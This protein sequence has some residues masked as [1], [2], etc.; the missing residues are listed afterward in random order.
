MKNIKYIIYKIKEI[1]IFIIKKDISFINSLGTLNQ[2]IIFYYIIFLFLLLYIYFFIY[3]NY[4]FFLIIWLILL[5]Y[6]SIVDT[7]SYYF[8]NNK[9]LKIFIKDNNNKFN[10]ILK[11]FIFFQKW[12]NPLLLLFLWVDN[13]YFLL[14]RFIIY[15]LK[16]N[17]R[18]SYT[19]SN[20]KKFFFLQYLILNILLGPLKM[21]FGFFYTMLYNLVEMPFFL[22]LLIRSFGLVLNILVISHLF[23]FFYNIWGI[24][25]FIYLYILF[26][27]IS[28]IIKLINKDFKY[29]KIKHLNLYQST[30]YLIFIRNSGTIFGLIILNISI[31]ND[32]KISIKHI[33]TISSIFKE[34]IEEGFQKNWIFYKRNTLLYTIN[35]WKE[36]KNR[37]S[38]FLYQVL[39]YWISLPSTYVVNSPTFITDIL[40][41]KYKIKKLNLNIPINLQKN[42]DYLYNVDFL[43]LKLL[44]FIIWDI[45]DYIN[46]NNF[47]HITY[48]SNEGIY[49]IGCDLNVYDNN[50]LDNFKVENNKKDLSFYDPEMNIEFFNKL[51][52]IIGT[53]TF[54]ENP[55]EYK[56]RSNNLNEYILLKENLINRLEAV[57]RDNDVLNSIWNRGGDDNDLNE[58]GMSIIEEQVK[59]WIIKFL[60]ETR[61]EWINFDKNENAIS[62]RNWRLLKELEN[63]FIK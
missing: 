60:N 51:Y 40:Y 12:K 42:I 63:L 14:L 35:I 43:R 19:E 31:Y 1:Y 59:N 21:F 39:I 61:N 33:D 2:L 52:N 44:L 26:I 13:I 47:N 48:I 50:N 45:D 6:K 3:E 20:F 53:L 49:N 10:K 18:I 56:I 41:I 22:F 37:P 9:D 57:Y 11:F 55:L 24:N 27:I 34:F 62:D 7:I 46:N 58:A 4:M 32:N 5:I 36:I 28:M 29:F 54:M 25:I 8:K 17:K 30:D 38:W 16:D 23:R 15:R